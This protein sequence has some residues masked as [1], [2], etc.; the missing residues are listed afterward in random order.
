MHA[1]SSSPLHFTL[2][3]VAKTMQEIDVNISRTF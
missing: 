3:W 2:G 1:E